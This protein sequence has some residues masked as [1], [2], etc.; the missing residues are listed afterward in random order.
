[1]PRVIFEVTIEAKDR[2]YDTDADEEENV[3][4]LILDSLGFP[5]PEKVKVSAK[6][7]RREEVE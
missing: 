2:G 5:D 6:L 7:I 4:D 1:M 3:V